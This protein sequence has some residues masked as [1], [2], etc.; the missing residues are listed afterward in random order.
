MDEWHLN[1]TEWCLSGLKSWSWKPVIPQ[2]TVGSNPTY[3]ANPNFGRI[4]TIPT[5]D[6]VVLSMFSE[7]LLSKDT[8]YGKGW[9][10]FSHS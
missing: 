1:K 10:G 5:N 7:N 2:G 4:I 3:S 6:S 8:V 9:F